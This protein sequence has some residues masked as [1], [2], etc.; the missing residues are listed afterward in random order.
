MK[1]YIENTVNKSN[2]FKL[3]HSSKEGNYNLR[4]GIIQ[5]S[6]GSKLITPA[7]IPVATNASIRALDSL[8]L[9]DLEIN[10]IFVN[11]YHMH[12]HPGEDIIQELGKLHKFMNYDGIIFTDSGGFQA[13]SLGQA[14]EH[15]VGKI[16]SI[17][18]KEGKKRNNNIEKL[19]EITDDYIIFKSHLDGKIIK[20]S[21]EKSIDIQIKLGSDILMVLDECTSPLASYEYT[22]KS[23]ERSMRWA[24]RS[25]EFFKKN[26]KGN[27]YL[28]GIIQG[29]HHYDL[30]IKSTEFISSLPFDGIAIGGSL[31]TSKENIKEILSWVMNY[32]PE[33][34][35]RHLLG[36]GSLNEIF[37]AI[38]N[39]IDTFDCVIPTRYARTGT[40]FTNSY[41]FIKDITAKYYNQIETKKYNKP[42][43][44]NC[45]CYTCRNY[46]VAY[47]NH[48]FFVG[49]IAAMTLLTIHNLYFY[50]N[51]LKNI[52]EAILQNR[53]LKFKEQFFKQT[54]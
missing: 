16:V 32:I 53:Y 52:R 41:P 14:I 7:F 44:E 46:T 13:F 26:N 4:I 18:S 35:P 27:Q 47:L 19:A 24:L 40:V 21:P 15:G 25:L 3:L 23:M 42:I 1:N 5:N 28:Y 31:G 8:K 22:K 37:T 54:S 30:R 29:G 2:F 51:L 45:N 38:E 11:T 10:G 9:K 12:V 50:S 33:N 34:L 36:I 17:F 6:L 39:G 43:D 49:E 20:L 48:L